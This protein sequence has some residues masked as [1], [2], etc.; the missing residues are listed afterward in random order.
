MIPKKIAAGEQRI[1][2]MARLPEHIT[3]LNAEDI[4]DAIREQVYES[5]LP[6]NWSWSFQFVWMTTIKRQ[7]A[8]QE[9][10]PFLQDEGIKMTTKNEVR[11]TG[12]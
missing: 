1:L 11:S 6:H 9:T 2:S 8:G 3:L 12:H 10:F 5:L 7:V 4:K